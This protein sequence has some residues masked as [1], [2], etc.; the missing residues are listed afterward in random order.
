[1]DI[2]SLEEFSILN[3][4]F[5]GD[6]MLLDV[7]YLNEDQNAGQEVMLSIQHCHGFYEMQCVIHGECE[8][9]IGNEL[10]HLSKGQFL[11]TA[12]GK[13]H[14]FAY[15]SSDI[16]KYV[17]CFNAFESGNASPEEAG[18]TSLLRAKDYIVGDSSD[19][20]MEL[21]K[22]ANLEMKCQSWSSTRFVRILVGL[23][24]VE[25]A[26]L[27]HSTES[28]ALKPA[29]T[30]EK[31]RDLRVIIAEKFINDNLDRP[32]SSQDVAASTHISIRQLDRLFFTETGM[33]V[34]K[35]IMKCKIQRAKQL[36]E[37]TDCSIQEISEQV[38]FS[39]QYNF[40]RFYKDQ[41]G[42]SPSFYRCSLKE[43]ETS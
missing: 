42:V 22:M 31:S 7:F 14:R 11:I 23:I 10:V 16:R 13:V 30:D 38:G 40:S 28:R 9:A 41:E 4:P 29:K 26:R 37:S 15:R 20:M 8:Y 3:I 18:M 12:P 25:V 39:S 35:N 32:L 19:T 21:F 2:N 36:L 1:M 5:A 24:I 6:G 43:A 33:T 34:K 17:L 27:F